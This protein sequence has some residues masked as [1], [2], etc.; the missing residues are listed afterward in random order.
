[1]KENRHYTPRLI[2][3]FIL[4]NIFGAGLSIFFSMVLVS[5]L[6][7]VPLFLNSIFDFSFAEVMHYASIPVVGK[8]MAIYGGDDFSIR[9]AM[10][11]MFFIIVIAMVILAVIG[12][13]L[14]NTVQG[15]KV[16][17]VL[18]GIVLFLSFVNEIYVFFFDN[19]Y[20]PDLHG[21]WYN[22]TATV[23]LLVSIFVNC[24]IVYFCWNYDEFK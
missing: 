17:A 24:N 7:L 3:T 14:I 20:N 5:I 9:L 12:S 18:T 13:F 10:L 15:S 22:I 8:L 21:I 1:M 23:L 6:I 4:S 2:G 11:I 19:N 16:M